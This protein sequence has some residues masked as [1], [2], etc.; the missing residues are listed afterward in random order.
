MSLNYS[1]ARRGINEIVYR[2]TNNQTVLQ[3]AVIKVNK[4][5]LD[6]DDMQQNYLPTIQY[7]DAQATA[8]PADP[9]W[10]EIKN[11]KDKVVADYQAIKTVAENMKTDLANYDP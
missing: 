2:I 6:L 11:I 4:V 8:N 7:I 9:L 3:E 10:T 5:I 1:N